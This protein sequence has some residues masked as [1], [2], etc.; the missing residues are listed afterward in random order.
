MTPT[1]ATVEKAVEKIPA[2]EEEEND[3]KGL[4]NAIGLITAGGLGGYLLL[5]R[6]DAKAR[7]RIGF[8]LMDS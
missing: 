6:K 1:E 7:S 2:K 3:W 5:S 4:F 8:G